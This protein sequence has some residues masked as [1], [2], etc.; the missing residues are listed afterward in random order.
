M[1]ITEI[2]E[3]QIA[4]TLINAHTIGSLRDKHD[5]DIAKIHSFKTLSFILEYFEKIE[6]DYQEKINKVKNAIEELK[7]FHAKE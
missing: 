4:G 5:L 2:T 6:G 3:K 7:K 1:N